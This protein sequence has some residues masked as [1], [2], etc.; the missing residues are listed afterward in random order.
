MP[1]LFD[2]PGQQKNL[3]HPVA[4]LLLIF[5]N[6]GEEKAGLWAFYYKKISI[7]H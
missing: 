5:A 2:I 1:K 4:Q 6:L 7:A 3:I